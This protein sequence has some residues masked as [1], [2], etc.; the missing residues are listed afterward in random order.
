MT[1][2][3]KR[4][5]ALLMALV[6]MFSCTV[7]ASAAVPE[8][9]NSGLSYETAF[10]DGG[11]MPLAQAHPVG[12]ILTQTYGESKFKNIPVA[13]G[14]QLTFTTSTTTELLVDIYKYNGDRITG[15]SIPNTNATTRNFSLGSGYVGTI[16]VTIKPRVANS[17][18]YI[19]V[20]SLVY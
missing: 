8:G 5:L 19:G 6:L 3:N 2:I 9:T 17:G 1:K 16:T 12:E 4:V 13:G 18:W 20:L 7:L 11:I 10:E 14:N 15:Y